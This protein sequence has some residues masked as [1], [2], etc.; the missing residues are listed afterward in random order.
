MATPAHYFPLKQGRYQVSAGLCELGKDFGNGRQDGQIFQLDSLFDPYHQA[1][2]QARSEQLAKYYP[3]SAL[4]P[5][6]MARVQQFVITRLIAEY[7]QYFE[8]TQEESTWHLHCAL[9][10][11]VLTFDQSLENLINVQAPDIVVPYRDGLDALACQVQED[12]ALVQRTPNG[13][14]TLKAVHLCFPNH[15]G[16]A[17]KMGRD[18]LAVHQPVPGMAKIN[19]THQQL[20]DALI[21]KGPYVRFAWGVATDNRLNHHPQSPSKIMPS[22]WEGRA[23]DPLDPQLYLR[24][25]RQVM[26][27]LPELEI[28]LFT[29]R[30]YFTDCTTLTP[31][32]REQLRSALASMPMQARI[33]KGLDQL[34]EILAW[35][36]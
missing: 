27:G 11:T 30:T 9:T 32:Q 19:H 33:Y 17:A 4:T 10:A 12:L 5:A 13:S 31:Q 25:E 28:F 20:I 34:D 8:L 7:P 1:K 24:I 35:L 3:D 23:F 15:W 2:Q 26:W 6:A 29:I 36:V 22:A 21:H 14:N 16:A 18:F